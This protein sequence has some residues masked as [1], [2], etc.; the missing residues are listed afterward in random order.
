MPFNGVGIFE[1][2]PS[3]TYPAVAG[4]LIKA[5]N[6]NS[7]VDDLIDGLTNCLTR[8]GQSPPSHNLPM[9]GFRLTDLGDGSADGHSVNFGQLRIRFSDITAIGS[10]TNADYV[11]SASQALRPIITLAG[12]LTGD[13]NVVFP[14]AAGRWII[15]NNTTGAFSVTCKNATGPAIS[16][17]QTKAAHLW[18]TGTGMYVSSNTLEGG[19]LTGPLILAGDATDPLN[20]ATYQQLIKNCFVGEI[21]IAPGEIVPTGYLECDGSSLLRSA[22][23]DLFAEIGTAHGTADATHFNLPDLRGVFLRGW[24]HGS[25]NDPDAATREASHTGGATGDHVGSKQGWQIQS[26]THGG[27]ALYDAGL[28][29]PGNYAGSVHTTAAIGSTG[30]NQTNP[31]NVNVMFL[32]RYAV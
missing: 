16:I 18:S 7:I 6:F 21:V 32:I 4:A 27:A 15:Q 10:L 26:H 9:A 23:P 31:I 29:I 25:T 11:L 5:S 8:D 2:L 30:G 17:P 1:G 22:Y 3:P 28:G 14:A 20:P 24:A 13:I 12:A 19:T